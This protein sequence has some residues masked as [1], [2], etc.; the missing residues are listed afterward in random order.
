MLI[1]CSESV[2]D[3]K[4]LFSKR[5]RRNVI[6]DPQQVTLTGKGEKVHL[7][8]DFLTNED[9]PRKIYKYIGEKKIQNSDICVHS[10]TKPHEG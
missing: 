4:A 10:S 1:R 8:S 9:L 6:Q 5:L 3:Q 2:C 7:C